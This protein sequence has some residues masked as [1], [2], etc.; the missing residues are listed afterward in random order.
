[1]FALRRIQPSMS[2]KAKAHELMDTLNR[3]PSS[4]SVAHAMQLLAA[5]PRIA[6][7]DTDNKGRTPLHYA[8]QL[9]LAKSEQRPDHGER[10]SLDQAGRANPRQPGQTA[11]AVEAHEDG[12]GLIVGVVGRWR[13]WSARA[14]RPRLQAPRSAPPARG[15]EDCP[16][17]HRPKGFRKEYRD[18]RNGARPLRILRR[19]R[20]GARDRLSP[21]RSCRPARHGPAPA[22]PCCP[23]PRRRPI[24]AF[25]GQTGGK[26]RQKTAQSECF[27]VQSRQLQFT[28]ARLAAYWLCNRPL[29]SAG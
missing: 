16:R 3:T 13:W 4:E 1:M 21:P 12:F 8:A 14:P 24:R 11:T 20:A 15:P 2:N 26:V 19:L 23:R 29:A 10:A 5:S 25:L 18:L 7:N 6:V 22:W 27:L 9:R 17:R 28:L